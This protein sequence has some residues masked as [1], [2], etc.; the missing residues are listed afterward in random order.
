LTTQVLLQFRCGL[1]PRSL[2]GKYLVPNL[3]LLGGGE[4]FP[5]MGPSRKPS[6]HFGYVLEG[7]NGI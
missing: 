7:Y 5:E 6:G 1:L 2:C 4:K 3:V